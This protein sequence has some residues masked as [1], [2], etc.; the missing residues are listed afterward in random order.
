MSLE[1]QIK[2][3][4]NLALVMFLI[5]NTVIIIVIS[6]DVLEMK[7]QFRQIQGQLNTI[8]LQ[9]TGNDFKIRTIQK[10]FKLKEK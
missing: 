7:K 6:F 3:T 10:N 5:F 2:C 4:I 8:Q 1:D 9:T